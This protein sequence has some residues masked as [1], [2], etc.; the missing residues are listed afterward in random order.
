[1]NTPQQEAD[2]LIKKYEKEILSGK[3]RVDGFVVKELAENCAIIHAEGIV[4]AINDSMLY[5]QSKRDHWQQVL[6]I[7]KEK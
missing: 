7:L 5:K 6:N 4:E 3:Y 2:E 1:M